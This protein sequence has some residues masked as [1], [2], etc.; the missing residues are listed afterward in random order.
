VIAVNLNQGADMKTTYHIMLNGNDIS[1][2]HEDKKSAMTSFKFF[3]SYY[4][5]NAKLEIV[6][7]EGK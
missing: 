4:G 3:Q 5:K 1:I 2:P 6:T 7:K